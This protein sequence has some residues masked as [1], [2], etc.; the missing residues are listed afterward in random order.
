MPRFANVITAAILAILVTLAVWA[1]QSPDTAKKTFLAKYAAMKS[2]MASRDKDSVLAL[3]APGFESVDVDGKVSDAE[4]M[5]REVGALPQ[6]PKKVS[7]TDVLSVEQVDGT[8][9]VKQRYHMMTT[10]TAKDGTQQAVDVVATSTDTWV[11][12]RGEWLLRRTVT[13]TL[14]YRLNGKLVVHKQQRASS[15]TGS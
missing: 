15:A 11:S 1:A 6:D 8:A 2:A 4:S 10:R 3:L 7:E 9:V 14:D 13:E 5:A 12:L